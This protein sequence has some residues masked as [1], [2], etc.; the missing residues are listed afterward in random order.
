MLPV[1]DPPS[2]SPL[3]PCLYKNQKYKQKSYLHT[4]CPKGQTLCLTLLDSVVDQ[5]LLCIF[6][7]WG[8]HNSW[9]PPDIPVHH[10]DGSG[11]LKTPKGGDIWEGTT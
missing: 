1:V 7:Y 10:P 9:H 5:D 2:P 6:Y 11:K 3:L 4:A 8:I